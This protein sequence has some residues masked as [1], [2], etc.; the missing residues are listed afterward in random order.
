MVKQKKYHGV[1]VPMVTPFTANGEIDLEAAGRITDYLIQ[2]GVYPFVIGTTGESP[3][4]SPSAKARFVET[5]VKKNA[6]RTPTY[7]G[8]MDNCLASSVKMAE[9]FFELGVD[10]VVA[11][12]PSYYPLTS[13]DILDY[14]EKLVEHV[15]GPL[16]L[17]NIPMTTGVSIPLELIDRL[18]HHSAIIGLKDSLRD[19]D[20]MKQAVDLWK[21]REDF[22]YLTGCT[23]LS[24]KALTMGADGIVPSVGNIVPDL[25]N[26]LYHAVLNGNMEQAEQCQ[27]RS[28]K[29]AELFQKNRGLSESLPMLKAII[30][31][32]GFCGPKVLPPLRD[33]TSD[34][35]KALKED[36]SLMGLLEGKN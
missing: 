26:K 22:A 35:L 21:G 27:K 17:Y 36:M 10:V 11:C 23:A 16:M 5:V 30:H 28:D 25:F 7:A 4:I 19:I 1:V 8:I 13:D 2:G 15:P 33:I 20:R 6:G 9:Q 14:F 32:L 34:Q 3:S 18:S 24:S 29:I 31:L 12:V